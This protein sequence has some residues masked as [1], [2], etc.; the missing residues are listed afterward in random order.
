MTLSGFSKDTYRNEQC[1]QTASAVTATSIFNNASCVYNVVI[2]YADEKNGQ[3][4]LSLYVAD[5]QCATFKLADDFGVWRRRTF[6][7]ITIKNGD[8]I[9]LVGIADSNKRVHADY[10]EFVIVK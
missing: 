2:S 10:I 7:N 3:G 4:T 6:N 1:A 9:K 5:K 8:K